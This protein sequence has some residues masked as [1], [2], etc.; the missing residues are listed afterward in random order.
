MS[1][2]L[3]SW[4]C[5]AALRS[6]PN[7]FGSFLAPAGDKVSLVTLLLFIVW[8][9]VTKEN[10]VSENVVWEYAGIVIVVRR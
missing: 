1:C 6:S 7:V 9:L 2:Q 5:L 3:L 4:I 8:N 10:A